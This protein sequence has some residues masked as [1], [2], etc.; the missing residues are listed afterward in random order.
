[1][2][3]IVG[4]IY[5]HKQLAENEF[6]K[7]RRGRKKKEKEIIILDYR[8]RVIS[9]ISATAHPINSDRD[10]TDPFTY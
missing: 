1:M 7:S 3:V 5:V 9:A 10:P 8:A 4:D 6:R 2:R